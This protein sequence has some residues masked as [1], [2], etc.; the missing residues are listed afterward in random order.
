M[1]TLVQKMKELDLDFQN[2]LLKNLV[3]ANKSNKDNFMKQME[4]ATDRARTIAEQL[5][6]QMALY[7]EGYGRWQTS[8]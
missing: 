2:R 1:T 6:A 4:K 5:N 7:P 3:S 8:Y